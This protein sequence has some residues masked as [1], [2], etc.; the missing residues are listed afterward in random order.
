MARLA[1]LLDRTDAALAVAAGAIL[2]PLAF[3]I[4][5]SGLDDLLLDLFWVRR[6]FHGA[7]K[8]AFETPAND[9]E[10]RLAVWLPLWQEAEVIGQMLEHNISAVAYSNWEIFIG[11]Y[12]NDDAT[13]SAARLL[14]A[15]FPQV[16]IVMV[17]NPG[18]TSKAD[19]L[20]S[21]RAGMA[22]WEFEHGVEFDGIV[23][24][25]AEDLIHPFSLSA[26]S[27]MLPGC[28]MIQVPVL[29]LKTPWRELT[30]GVYC[31]D[32]AE[33][34][35]K[36][37]ETRVAMGG[38]LPGCGV[39]TVLSKAALRKLGETG[40]VFRQGSLTEDYDTGL[41]LHRLGCRQA[42]IPL[43]F[44][45][46]APMATREYFPRRL[47]Q[48]IRQRSRWVTGN[49]LQAWERY[50]WGSNTRNWWFLWRDR[51]G[52]WGNPIS[53]LCNLVLIYGM[54]SWA[55]S[56]ATGSVWRLAELVRSSTLFEWLLIVNTA[57]LLSRLVFRA[58]ASAR[59]Y[60]WPFALLSP[61]RMLW[62]NWINFEATL[63]A[64]AAW[65][66]SRIL[67][68]PLAWVKTAHVYPH[69][70]SLA[71]H[72]RRIGEILAS[73]NYCTREEVEL[74]ATTKPPGQRLGERLIE[75]GVIDEALLYEALSLQQDLPCVRIEPDSVPPRVARALP[76]DVIERCGV[77]PFRIRDGGLDVAGPW[78]VDAEKQRMLQNYTRLELRF[79]LT[80]PSDYDRLRRK[81]MD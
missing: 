65:L 24:H 23:I 33:S 56:V 15:R 41:R 69:R 10:K 20:N 30:H 74:A 68:Q 32:F 51:K 63:R 60:G 12:P 58:A 71:G 27:S 45:W 76:G 46:G 64:L 36:D 50:G 53:L 52:L 1:F 48:A 21:I 2:L 31:D 75:M 13:M 70:S 55:A 35:G 25:D 78:L 26:I 61:V 43:S 81:V 67:N 37:L 62:G 6:L 4:L 40:D 16:H 73:N 77:I 47:R 19:N 17:P 7:W 42:F 38:F 3:Y 72:K 39:G 49:S 18:P 22:D 34:Q 79:H 14:E 54:T 5:L 80:P 28:D 11:C 59:V 9:D 57:L 29:P 66:R 44:E 8:P